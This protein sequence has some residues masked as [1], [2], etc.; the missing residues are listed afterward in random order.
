MRDDLPEQLGAFTILRQIG[1]GGMGR[2]YAAVQQGEGEFRKKAAVKVLLGDGTRTSKAREAFLDEARILG[3]LHHPNIVSIYDL[4]EDGDQ[5]WLAMEYVE[6]PTLSALLEGRPLDR[7]AFSRIAGGLCAGLDYAHDL[8][9]DGR[10]LNLVHRD[11]K[12]GNILIGPQGTPRI[13]DFGIARAASN[14]RTLTATG[15]PKGTWWYMSPEQARGEATDRRSDLFSL[16]LV[17]YEMATGRRLNE[18]TGDLPLAALGRCLALEEALSGRREQDR[19]P[20]NRLLPGLWDL[21]SDLVRNDPDQR[22]DS[23]GEVLVRLKRLERPEPPPHP[24]PIDDPSPSWSSGARAAVIAALL[25]VAVVAVLLVLHGR[26]EPDPTAVVVHTSEAESPAPSP[27][28]SVVTPQTIPSTPTPRPVVTPARTP[29]P[30]RVEAATPAPALPVVLVLGDQATASSTGDDSELIV[31]R[32]E[33][34]E[35]PGSVERL[36]LRARHDSRQP[37]TPKSIGFPGGRDGSATVS[38]S[39]FEVPAPSH[40]YW[41]LVGRVAGSEVVLK[42]GRSSIER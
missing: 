30:E 1:Q 41:Q 29:P 36:T 25:G 32:V 7:E 2:V 10:P 24:W 23:A 38:W 31:L 3:L 4:G 22:P 40:V 35:P 14:T 42:D 8:E 19:D 20:V 28:A 39:S 21:L 9:V 18:I 27:I 16:G 12:P 6:G 33:V 26:Q 37:W 5:I 34:A 15:V 17:L 13:V 11:L